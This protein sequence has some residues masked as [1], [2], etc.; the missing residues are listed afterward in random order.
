MDVLG[1]L[2]EVWSRKTLEDFFKD[3]IFGP[4]G[5]E[6]AHFY[7]PESK[8]DRLVSVYMNSDVGIKPTEYTLTKY[9]IAGAKTYLSGGADLSC[10]AYDYF[11]FCK[12]IL[13]KG[14]AKGAQ[15][16]K[17]ETID[18][19]SSTHLETGDN[20]MGLGFGVL[21]NKNE[22]E[23]ARSIGS[24]TWGGFFSTTFWIDPQEE[25]IAILM[26][27]MYPFDYWEIQKDFEDSIYTI[28]SEKNENH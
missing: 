25:V 22:S 21:S 19:I 1:R 23:L 7:L 16:L 4:I 6:D 18:L 8:Y 11:L 27:Q 3:R 13:D 12:M 26:L 2:V 14:M 10:T 9:P 20:N 24:I 28:I 15:I 17:P 5:M